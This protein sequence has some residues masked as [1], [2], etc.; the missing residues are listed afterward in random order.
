RLARSLVDGDKQQRISSGVGGAI[1]G[2]IGTAILPGIGTLAGSFLGSL[3]GGTLAPGQVDTPYSYGGFGVG[4]GG[5]A[6]SGFGADNGGRSGGAASLGG[7]VGQA[8][9]ARAASQGYTW[10]GD[11]QTPFS[12]GYSLANG[13]YYYGS[14]PQ[15][16][17]ISGEGVNF[18]HDQ[19]A[20]ENAIW[21]DL[22]DG[23]YLLSPEQKGQGQRIAGIA[24]TVGSIKQGGGIR[25]DLYPEIKEQYGDTV[26]TWDGREQN[27]RDYAGGVYDNQ[28][29]AEGRIEASDPEQ[30][31][32]APADNAQWTTNYDPDPAS[33]MGAREGGLI[34]GPSGIKTQPVPNF[35]AHTGEFVIRPEAVAKYG[36]EF[37]SALNRGQVPAPGGGAGDDQEEN[38]EG[39][40]VDMV[41][42]AE[43]MEHEAAETSEQEAHEHSL[44]DPWSRP[45]A[46]LEGQTSPFEAATAPGSGATAMMQMKALPP[47][48]QQSLLL[49]IGQNPMVASAW[50]AVLGPSYQP[51]ISQ[52]LKVGAAAIQQ[53]KMMQQAAMQQQ[54][55][56]PP[57]AAPGMM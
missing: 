10:N 13:N 45:Y 8:I 3:A 5:L 16:A 40:G 27:I 44:S 23:G 33:S 28:K 51:L 7:N 36:P 34:P 48:V 11:Q 32:T 12:K 57:G 49:S 42:G 43:D 25:E 52:A 6:S 50:L 39:E 1:G 35:T 38:E 53:A 21:G 14:G 46:D 20:L 15:A 55:V 4:A 41:E 22:T 2:A 54:G 37:L 30:S 56:R 18:G 29:V 9:N 17:L 24:N 19:A 26:V 31:A 47:Q